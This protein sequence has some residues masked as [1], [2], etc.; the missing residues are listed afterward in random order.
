MQP[1]P[2][3]YGPEPREINAAQRGG[4]ASP[5][6]EVVLLRLIGKGG[7][8]TVWRARWG[9]LPVAVKVLLLW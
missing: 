2:T 4:R 8:G 9:I 5:P 7:Q 3:K 1:S 6:G